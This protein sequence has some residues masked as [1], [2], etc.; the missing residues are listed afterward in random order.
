MTSFSPLL[1]Q[2]A[3]ING[4]WVAADTGATFPVVNP[5]DDSTLGTVPDLGPAETRRAIVAAA[6]AFPVWRNKTAAARSAILRRWYELQVEQQEALAQLLTAEQG[7][8]IRE[9][10][11]EIRYGASFVEWFAEEAR[12][13][14]GD[15]IPG[16][17]ADKRILALRQ[18][19]G[20]VA[21]I[22]P[23]N[24]PNAMITR[25]VAPALAAGCPVVIK[26]AEDTPLS[27]LALA[28]LAEEAGFPPG[29]FNVVTTQH[30][31]EVGEELTS[32]PLVRKLSFTGSTAVGKRLYQQCATTV[33]K[34]SLELGGNAPFIVFD[35]ADLEAAVAGAIASKYRNAGQTCVCANR[36]LVQEGIYEA[37]LTALT[38]ATEALQVGEGRAE[39]T[40]IGPLINEAA[41]VKVAGLLQEAQAAGA[42]L[43]TG[44]TRLPQNTRFFQPTV[45]ADAT[46]EMRISQEEIF[47]PVAAVYRFATEAEAIRLANDTAAGLAAYFYGRDHARC[48]RV[49]E[50]LDYGI[51]GINTGMISTAVAPFGGIKESG[52]GR[53]GSRYGMEEFQEIKYVCWGGVA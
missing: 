13:A 1:R 53:E 42:R 40:D 27:A 10:R 49:A 14:Y 34:I 3:Y 9:A 43:L 20:V 44:G 23:W 26:P 31:A 30:P 11:G 8:P 45:V 47:G 51:V 16:H 6:T 15:I 5:Y 22:T 32:H 17:A 37:F 2:Q 19:V 24:F 36:I 28:A 39:E 35:D 41:R 52:L 21:A 18:P 38:R 4:Q 12:R 50:A 48:W 7:K 46:P 29:V 25:K 33:K